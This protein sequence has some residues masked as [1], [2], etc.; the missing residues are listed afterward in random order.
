MTESSMHPDSKKNSICTEDLVFQK[1][2]RIP[3]P[4]LRNLWIDRVKSGNMDAVDEFLCSMDGH[5]KNLYYRLP[6][7]NQMTEDDTYLALRKCSSQEIIRLV[8]SL[9]SDGADHRSFHEFLTFHHWTRSQYHNLFL[10]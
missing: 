6:I 9:K 10:E 1:L 2:S 5:L 7:F 4:E 8:D 3:F